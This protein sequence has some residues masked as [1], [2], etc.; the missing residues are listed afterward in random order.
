MPHGVSVASPT[1]NGDLLLVSLS[2]QPHL[3]DTSFEPHTGE[4]VAS[5][6]ASIH[7]G[8]AVALV[9]VDGGPIAPT[10]LRMRIAVLATSFDQ[11][12]AGYQ[13]SPK[14]SNC[15]RFTASFGRGSSGGCPAGTSSE[16]WCS[17]FAQFVWAHSGVHTGGIS[18]WAASFI[19]WGQAHHRLQLGTHFRPGVGDAIVW[20]Q[21]SPLY[22]THVAII[23]AVDGPYI[24]VV[25]GNSPGGF[26][27]N[28]IGVW[29]WGPF[30]AAGSSVNGYPVL[31]VVTP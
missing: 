30:G 14:W 3:L 29:R 28:G 6:V 11:E 19:I 25:S 13:T 4:Y 10:A 5:A 8:S 1:S 17:D 23:V 15:N 27:G 2:S 21:R 9:A 16:E 31:G 12:H 7:V 18:G 26:P 22:G 24:T 20:G